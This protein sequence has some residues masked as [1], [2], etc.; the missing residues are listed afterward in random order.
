[1]V[2]KVLKIA[3]VFLSTLNRHLQVVSPCSSTAKTQITLPMPV[4]PLREMG[5]FF[6]T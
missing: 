3:I 1:M 6:P 5:Q 2:L 4:A